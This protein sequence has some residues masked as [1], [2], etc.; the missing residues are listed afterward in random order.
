PSSLLHLLSTPARRSSD[1]EMSGHMFF[2]D[3]YPGYDDA[4]YAALRLI[5]ILAAEG[6]TIEEL[7]SDLPRRHATPELRLDCPDALKFQVVEDRKSTRL[8]SSHVKI[9]YA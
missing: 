2:A 9:S 4:I 6:R 8:N 1:L 5:E 3:R 7:L